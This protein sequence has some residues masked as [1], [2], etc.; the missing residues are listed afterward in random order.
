VAGR[1]AGN[2]GAARGRRWVAA[3][4]L[5]LLAALLLLDAC[6]SD[7]EPPGPSRS[8]APVDGPSRT[9]STAATEGDEAAGPSV[10][11]GTSTDRRYLVDQRGEPLLLLAETLWDARKKLT[12]PQTREH[13][14]LRSRQGFN[15]VL[16]TPFPWTGA[17][18]DRTTDLAGN[19]PFDGDVTHLD[20]AYW[21]AFD[22]VLATA[23]RDGITVFV[24]PGGAAPGFEAAGYSYDDAAA[25]GLGEALGRRYASTPG[26]VWLFGVDYL[27]QDWA[28]YDP[29]MMAFV[30]GLRAGGDRHL[31]TVQLDNHSV[32]SDDATWRPVLGIEAAYTYR[33]T[34]RM[35]LRG[36][37]QDVAPVMLIESNF[38]GEN[39]E[40]GPPTTDETLRRQAYWTLTSGGTG[41]AYGSGPV[42]QMAPGWQDRRRT[43]GALQTAQA[44]SLFRSVDWWRLVPDVDGTFLVSGRGD[45]T[46]TGTLE[47]G[48]ADVLE[49]NRATAAITGDG[50]LAAVYVPT[51]RTI[52]LDL[53]RL[54]AGARAQWCDPVSGR[55]KDASLT[56]RMRT[57]GSNAGGDQDWLLLVRS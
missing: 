11:E 25:R 31:V 7:S 51:S 15:A 4:A 16:L 40:G 20:E 47:G 10:V 32:S 23:R 49:S 1:G 55:C 50:S 41:V 2:A 45:D 46:T 54:A 53:G 33:P 38:E 22:R 13:F 26:I 6:S 43:P 48:F 5:G 14:A 44:V 19:H 29:Q 12:L 42:W 18:D 8:S 30:E 37:E 56:A 21:S 17:P 24:A 35:V 9:A 36:Y 27:P 34:Y 39:N 57:P 28:R 52:G 3:V